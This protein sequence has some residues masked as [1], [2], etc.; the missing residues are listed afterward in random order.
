MVA[1]AVD[2]RV[3]SK[4]LSR[5]TLAISLRIVKVIHVFLKEKTYLLDT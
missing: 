2:Y 5:G 1:V 3:C 4:A